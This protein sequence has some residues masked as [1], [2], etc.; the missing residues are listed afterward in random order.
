MDG[1]EVPVCRK[2]MNQQFG[3]EWTEQKLWILGEYLR[4][5]TTA[6]KKKN[7]ELVYVDAFAGTGEIKLPNDDEE[8]A[9]FCD[10]S[11]KI[12]LAVSDKPFDQ[13]IFIER[14]V[15]KCM[16]LEAVCSNYPD[17]KTKVIHEDANNYIINEL[18][19]RW[20]KRQRGVIFLDPF[21]IEVKWQTIEA[22]SSLEALDVW[23][24][25]PTST[26]ARLLPKKRLPEAWSDPLNSVY[27]D[28]SWRQLYTPEEPDLF[29]YEAM[30]REQGVQGLLNIYKE[31]LRREFGERYLDESKPLLNSKNSRLFELLFCVGNPHGIDLAKKLARHF[32]RE[33]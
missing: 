16:K 19:K 4:T 3:G 18:T 32:L 27:G 20:S 33:I 10:G 30:K 2:G 15:E 6:L 9:S 26:I 25:F 11:A 17:R 5:Y 1:N 24:L 12:A 21:S 31:K 28:N 8:L 29:G 22:I 14:D 13:L 7:F 23:I